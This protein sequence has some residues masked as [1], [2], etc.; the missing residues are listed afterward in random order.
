MDKI[1]RYNPKAAYQPNK[2]TYQQLLTGK[3]LTEQ[4]IVTD[5]QSRGFSIN[6]VNIFR[7]YDIP[8]ASPYI[9]NIWQNQAFSLWQTQLNFAIWLST[10]GCGISVEHLNASNS[11]VRA[12][13]R[14]HVMY[15]TR[16]TLNA[17]KVFLPHQE[18][19]DP[20]LN[21][22][23]R[24]SYHAI[25]R[26]YDI[27]NIDESLW[28]MEKV[29]SSYQDKRKTWDTPG[30]EYIDDDS[31]ARWILQ[32]SN[33]LTRIGLEK[34]SESVREYAY[35]ILSAQGKART[36]IIGSTGPAIEAQDI[37]L[38]SFEAM[39]IIPKDLGGGI[40]RFQDVLRY[41]RSKVDFAVAENV[42][43][44]PADLN[45]HMGEAI[46]FN[47]KIKVSKSGF[48]LGVNS[49]INLALLKPLLT[50][51]KTSKMSSKPSLTTSSSTSSSSTTSSKLPSKTLSKP[52][53]YK[54]IP[55]SSKRHSSGEE[56][57]EEIKAL[58]FALAGMIVF[59]MWYSR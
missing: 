49:H 51:S 46:K 53:V 32:E 25:L 4:F 22:F 12:V 57:Q 1:F 11:M 38:S 29:F 28:R 31:W 5:Q 41:A 19:F 3:A 39:I 17:L 36:Q 13:Y 42:Y 44:I 14:F 10:S 52:S 15:Q 24:D 16:K 26:F 54:V 47:N 48:R 58:I 30:L 21:S 27:Q 34:I 6:F 50:S 59:G 20:F 35:L 23:D 56:H 7:N 43:M 45:L 40:S 9:I 33:G 18:G 55:S 8:N 2:G 37:F